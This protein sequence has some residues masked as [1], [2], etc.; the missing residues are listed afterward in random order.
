M[1]LD[2]YTIYMSSINVNL[3]FNKLEAFF[4]LTLNGKIFNFNVF[5]DTFIGVVYGSNTYGLI[6]NGLSYSMD[7]T[8]LFGVDKLGIFYV[9]IKK[10]D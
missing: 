1:E 10:D 2:D 7:N 6:K 3:L 4:K 8:L 9:G 5:N